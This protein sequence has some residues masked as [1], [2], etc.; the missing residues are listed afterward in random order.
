M[1]TIYNP[2]ATGAKRSISP[3][4]DD[5]VMTTEARAVSAEI[6]RA[7][8]REGRRDPLAE[9]IAALSR[10]KED[11][12]KVKA[13]ATQLHDSFLA[14]AG[15][16][17]FERDAYGKPLE[18]TQNPGSYLPKNSAAIS[19]LRK[20]IGN[21]VGFVEGAVRLGVSHGDLSDEAKAASRSLGSLLLPYRAMGSDDDAR[22]AMNELAAADPKS[23]AVVQKWARIQTRLKQIKQAED[24]TEMELGHYAAARL[25]RDG[26]GLTSAPEF[27][28]GED[29]R[30]KHGAVFA[31]EQPAPATF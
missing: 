29:N 23:A 13:E 18:D 1:R 10:R 2:F 4:A 8:A 19:D 3:Y 21:R 26:V 12:G 22:T 27:P 7:Y 15:A 25:T 17:L 28:Q 24:E 31:G 14:E 16:G 20:K 9:Q 30:L 11:I 6:G 5:A